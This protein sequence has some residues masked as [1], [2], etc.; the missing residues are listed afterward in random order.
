MTEP[1]LVIQYPYDCIEIALCSSL[2]IIKRVE[3]HKFEAIKLLIPTIND[4]LTSNNLTL[5][6][7]ICI[8]INR[9]PGPYNTLRSIIS[10]LNGFQFTHE[11][12]FVELEALPLLLG[13]G[14]VI[15][16]KDIALGLRS[17][18]SIEINLPPK[19]N[20]TIALLNAFARRVYY[21]IKIDGKIVQG[22]CAVTELPEI[23]KK[24]NLFDVSVTCVGNGITA[25]QEQLAELAPN[26]EI[27]EPSPQ[28]NSLETLISETYKAI[29]AQE[30][31][32]SYIEPVYFN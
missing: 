22:I 15:A 6:D 25:Y 31:S 2:K 16:V 5:K 18:K 17:R 26:L 13:T 32:T 21:G 28:F 23:L 12:K 3:I 11:M 7:L 27:S 10:T 1:F 19:T 14:S 8:G 24:H 29:Q 9:G 30:F 4:L 20:P